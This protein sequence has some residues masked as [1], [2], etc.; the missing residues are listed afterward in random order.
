MED[1]ERQNALK[2]WKEKI[3]GIECKARL[4]TLNKVYISLQ[5]R[6]D[7]ED[8]Y[9][10][11]LSV[12]P[13]KLRSFSRSK[14]VKSGEVDFS[15][16][17]LH[18][19]AIT[20]YDDLWESE[21]KRVLCQKCLG[22]ALEVFCMT[23]KSTVSELLVLL[24]QNFMDVADGFEL[25]SQF[26]P[27]IQGMQGYLHQFHFLAMK[28]G[29]LSKCT[30][31]VLLRDGVGEKLSKHSSSGWPYAASQNRRESVPSG[32]IQVEDHE[33]SCQCGDCLWRKV[34]HSDDSTDDGSSRS[35]NAFHTTNTGQDSK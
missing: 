33:Y 29:S 5:D 14:G 34:R 18:A 11:W 25:Y 27:A 9:E 7:D 2:P 1:E 13:R 19:L 17:W 32:E 24:E 4:R 21:K 12:R 30:D 26:R 8:E 10:Q 16:W 20:K 31:D 22:L 23:P 15:T 28:A 6:D 3:G 35:T